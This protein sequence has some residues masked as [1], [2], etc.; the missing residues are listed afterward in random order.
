MIIA[1]MTDTHIMP[2]GKIWKNK[3]E[4]EVSERLELV[5]NHLN[6]LDPSPTVA[7]LTGDATDRGEIE[8]YTHLKEILSPLKMPTYIVPGNHDNRE[9]LRKVFCHQSYMPPSGLIHYVINDYPVRLIGLDTTTEHEDYGTLCQERL[10]WL[11]NA[12][13]QDSQKPTLIFMHHPLIQTGNKLLDKIRCLTPEGFED[14]LQSFPNIIGIL[15]G[16][17]HRPYSAIFGKTLSFTAPSTAPSFFFAQED[18]EKVAAI[19]LV[20]PSF[21]LHK[22][23]GQNQLISE[24]IQ[25]VKPHER[26]PCQMDGMDSLDSSYLLSRVNG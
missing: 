8:A 21:T 16:H 22:W 24:V 6:S 7:L 25:A 17:Y 5:V 10:H 1:Q 23:L 15:S 26:L 2:K 14:M 13:Y 3:P 4:T 20:H 19:D 12:L 18:D 9:A 11:Q